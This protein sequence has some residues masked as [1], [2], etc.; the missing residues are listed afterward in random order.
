MQSGKTASVRITHYTF[1]IQSNKYDPDYLEHRINTFLESHK[2]WKP[3]EEEVEAA[4]ASHISRLQQKITNLAAESALNWNHII[5]KELD[6]DLR[7]QKIESYKNITVEAIRLIFRDVFFDNPRELIMKMFAHE[8]RDD[9][10]TRK[11]SQL[12]NEAFYKNE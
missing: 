8:K 5:K 3:T 9:L 7:E 2:D 4:K 6:F 10:E 11:E 1:L 12:L